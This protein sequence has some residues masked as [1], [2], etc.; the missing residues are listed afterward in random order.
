MWKTS[1]IF[2]AIF[3]ALFLKERVSAA[4]LKDQLK[5]FSE[6]AADALHDSHSLL[7]TIIWAIP[8]MGFLGTVL[9]IT[10]AIANVTPDKLDTSLP[11]VTSGLAIAFDTTALALV[12]SMI[13]MFGQHLVD[14]KALREAGQGG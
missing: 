6:T 1:V 5:F 14:R 7:Q 9:G 12:L 8:I 3:A 2:T 13:L 4:G 11:E 10:L